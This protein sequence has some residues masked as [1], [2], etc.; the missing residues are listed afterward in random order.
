[1]AGLRHE[2][3]RWYDQAARD[4]PWRRTRDPYAIWVS[5]VM[6]QQTRVETVI[7]YYERFLKRFPTPATLAAAD[8]DAVLSHWSGLGYY[9][10]ARLLHAGVREVVERY[11]GR[12]PESAEDR[13]ALPGVG[14]YTAGAIGSIAFDKPEPVVDGNV[15]R[16][17]ARLF[18]IDTPVGTAATTQRLWDE[19]ARLVPGERPG[20]LNQA[21]MELGATVCTAQSPR[22][23]ACPVAA[24]C[25]AHRRG[26]V[27]ALPVARA[28]K[29]PGAIALVAVVATSGKGRHRSVWLVRSE[30]RLFGGLWGVPM[31]Q[32]NGCGGDARAA[33]REAGISAR[34]APEPAARVEHVLTHRRLRL[35]VFRATAARAEESD[36]RRC[37]T[38][39]ALE[40]VG[41]S[42]LTRRLLAAASP[43]RYTA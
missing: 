31:V 41:V 2:L 29:A 36:T 18:G 22:C 25:V 27:D 16:V 20:A 28:R 37:F 23:G 26:V 30:A 17:L 14:R 19:A 32:R 3:L 38:D 10:R 11:G 34:L 43:S 7:P 12:V 15:T 8:E 9:R 21:L 39:A 1:M 13:R 6:L 24:D 42:T 40:E 33:L 4:L 5:E 35:E